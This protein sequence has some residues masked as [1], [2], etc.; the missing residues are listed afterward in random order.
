MLPLW[1]WRLGLYKMRCEDNIKMCINNIQSYWLLVGV[2][3]NSVSTEQNA[4][5]FKK[6]VTISHIYN[7]V[8]SEPTITRYTKI[9]R[10]TIKVYL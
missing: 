5:Q 4:G 1:K 6:K 2:F 3:N 8:T 7:D 9:D 10:K